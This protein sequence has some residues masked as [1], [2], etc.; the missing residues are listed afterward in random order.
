[1]LCSRVGRQHHR[2]Q[3]PVPDRMLDHAER[4]V[5]EYWPGNVRRQS[6]GRELR[7]L[8]GRGRHGGDVLHLRFAP[9]EPPATSRRQIALAV[10]TFTPYIEIASSRPVRIS[11]SWRSMP[12]RYCRRCATY[13]AISRSEI[14]K[15]QDPSIKA[16]FFVNP[17]NPPSVRDARRHSMARLRRSLIQ[18][19]RPD[20]IMVTDDVY[21][22][23]VPGFRSL[24]AAFHTT[25][26]RCIR[27]PSTSAAPGG[28]SAWLQ[29]TK[30]TSSTKQIAKLPEAV[31]RELNTR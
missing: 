19:D 1:M 26:S 25:P 15:L 23:F 8:C 7:H 6:A 5:H 13:L 4:V 9:C 31:R 2:G 28:A 20:L 14:D 29:F 30:T 10:P 21:G 22:T 27:S 24:M 12:V 3:V 18:N 11:T 16:L 17:S